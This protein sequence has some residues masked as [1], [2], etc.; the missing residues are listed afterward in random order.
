MCLAVPAR[1]IHIEGGMG[2]VEAGG[3]RRDVSLLLVEDVSVGDYVLVHAGF[4]LHKV[5]EQE[6]LAT[7]EL[8]RRMVTGAEGSDP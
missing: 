2:R 6:A 4:A 7:L 8:L 5:D 1:I 3:V